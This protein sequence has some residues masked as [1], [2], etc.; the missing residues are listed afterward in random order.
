MAKTPTV[1]VKDPANPTPEEREQV[2][3]ILRKGSGVGIV[4]LDSKPE[5]DAFDAFEPKEPQAP[6]LTAR[7]RAKMRRSDP[8]P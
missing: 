5:G 2:S 1:T 7:E 3:E 8:S 4:C 6:R